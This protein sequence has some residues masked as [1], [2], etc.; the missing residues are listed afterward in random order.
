[1]KKRLTLWAVGLA[2]LGAALLPLV[3]QA[4]PRSPQPAVSPATPAAP[5]ATPAPPQHPRIEAA[6]RHL[7]EAKKELQAAPDE[8]HGHRHMAIVR[9]DQALDECH[10]ALA[11]VSR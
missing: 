11:S 5:A 6:M 4:Q 3:F 8:F 9:V 1:M 10:K 7:E 2:I